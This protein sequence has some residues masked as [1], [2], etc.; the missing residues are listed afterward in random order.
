MGCS[1]A[2]GAGSRRAPLASGDRPDLPLKSP[3]QRCFTEEYTLLKKIGVGSF[4]Q[5][6][7]CTPRRNDGFA[8]DLLD[9]AKSNY[10]VKIIDLRL[11]NASEQRSDYNESV[12]DEAKLEAAKAEA[13][14]WSKL[15]QE[16]ACP[17]LVA[18]HGV[19][20]DG[21]L[22]FMVM[23]RCDMT[24]LQA[25]LK[26]PSIDELYLGRLFSQMAAALDSL[27][28]LNIVHRDIKP[29]N[30]LLTHDERVKLIDFGS[31]MVRAGD[32]PLLDVCNT[33]PYTAPEVLAEQ[34]YDEKADIWSLGALMYVL[35]FGQFHSA[36]SKEPEKISRH[37]EEKKRSQPSFQPWTK[38][39]TGGKPSLALNS[40]LRGMLRREPKTRVCAE[41][42]LASAFWRQLEEPEFYSGA[43]SLHIMLQGAIRAGAFEM[44]NLDS[45]D[46]TD[47]LLRAGSA[48]FETGCPASF[49]TGGNSYDSRSTCWVSGGAGSNARP[50]KSSV[51]TQ[52]CDNAGD[53]ASPSSAVLSSPSLSSS[54]LAMAGRTLEL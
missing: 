39:E 14:I 23:E 18:L 45:H 38:M 5:V 7:I 28:R 30:F 21:P 34:G 6:R 25:F 10:A 36:E 31:A 41:Q 44:P 49:E 51:P 16:S 40:L 3:V 29:D 37:A 13:S 4:A 20:W 48:S 26:A 42:V 2:S 27:H 9:A 47:Q 17:H 11:K 52:S 50:R 1:H 32:V 24:L 35:S 46:A 8:S 15:M 43:P 54:Q 19:F 33:T 12:T 22:C 53:G